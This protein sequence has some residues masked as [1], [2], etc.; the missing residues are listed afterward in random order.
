MIDALHV[1]ETGLNTYSTYLD[2]ISN[3]IANINTPGF[4][5]SAVNFS[6]LVY[7]DSHVKEAN[8]DAVTN[9]NSN[10]VGLGTAIGSTYKVFTAGNLVQTNNAMDLAINGRGFIEVELADGSVAY[11]R[12]GRLMTDQNGFLTTADGNKLTANIQLPPDIEGLFITQDGQVQA[13]L[14]SDNQPAL[15]GTIELVSFMNPEALNALGFN[16]YSATPEA[17]ESFSAAAGQAGSG[18]LLQGY[19]EVSNVSMTEEMV[20]MMTAQRAFQLNSRVVQV[21]DQMLETI[22]NM[23][24]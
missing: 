15:L 17:G 24:R 22:N 21:A 10:L 13:K 23:R 7:Q 1:A 4:K 5:K 3:N 11:T 20:N 2:V 8:T 18:S 14:V 9:F 12:A 16:L 19:S 6:D